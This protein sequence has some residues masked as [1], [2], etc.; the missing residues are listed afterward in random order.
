MTTHTKS[1]APA[2]NTCA[3]KLPTCPLHSSHFALYAASPRRLCED[4]STLRPETRIR[5]TFYR[6]PKN[7]ELDSPQATGSVAKGRE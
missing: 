2:N 3:F 6:A 7:T 4:F 5:N 1:Q